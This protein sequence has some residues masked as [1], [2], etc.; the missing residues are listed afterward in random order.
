MIGPST[1]GGM[2][3]PALRMTTRSPM[4]TPLRRTSS[5]LCSVASETVDPATTTGSM[6]ANGGD[7]PGPPDVDLDVEE[8]RRDLLGRVLE[9]DRPARRPR[10][11]TEPTLQGHLVDL[12]DDA[13]DLVLDVVAVLAPV[14]DVGDD[15]VDA[16]HD[17]R[18]LGDRQSPGAQRVV[19]WDSVRGVETL[20][21]AEAVQMR[22]RL[23]DPV[24]RGSFCRNEPAAV[25]RGLANGGLPAS[26]SEALS[27]WKSSSRK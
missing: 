11:G 1:S 27:A 7:P 26:T 24:T 18:P 4:S 9:R 23:R 13:V 3:S 17:L 5:A 8:L 6:N 19:G 2:T 12:D 14:L 16:L 10:R 20:A 22:R 21:L 25:L 15:V